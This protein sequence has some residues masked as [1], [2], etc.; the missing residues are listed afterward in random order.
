MCRM[1]MPKGPVQE[2][3][4]QPSSNRPGILHDEQDQ[5]EQQDRQCTENRHRNRERPLA[6]ELVT[7]HVGKSHRAIRRHGRSE[8][9]NRDRHLRHV[10]CVHLRR[11]PTKPYS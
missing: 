4:L 7:A 5:A 3:V 9:D 10:H 8:P 11:R 6:P 2:S 1:Q